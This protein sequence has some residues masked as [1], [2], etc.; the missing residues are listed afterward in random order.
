MGREFIPSARC[1]LQRVHLTPGY[2]GQ[3]TEKVVIPNLSLR[4]QDVERFEDEPI[5]FIRQDLEG[6]DDD[7][8]RRAATNFLRTLMEQFEQL[9]TGVVVRYVDPRPFLVL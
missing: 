6:A 2:V 7:T 5:E 9:V 3:I 4:E 8:R 1:P